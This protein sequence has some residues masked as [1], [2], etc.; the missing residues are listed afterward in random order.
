MSTADRAREDLILALLPVMMMAPTAAEGVAVGVLMALLAPL[1]YALGA[2]AR[3]EAHWRGPTA[4]VIAV[5]LAA[6]ALFATE[7]LW[8][9]VHQ[10][11]VAN[12]MVLAVPC[13]LVAWRAMAPE[14]RARFFEAASITA[15]VVAWPLL[16]GL[17][18]EALGRGTVFADAAAVL[19]DGA[20]RLSLA[21]SSSPRGIIWML[22]P[23]GALL[24]AGA[25]IALERAWHAQ[26]KSPT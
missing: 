22:E 15:R 6:C 23:A 21:A 26:E 14:P 19:G 24:I 8:P 18:R 7:A 17:L 13:A 25:L 10:A 5:M 4:I 11:L 20:A 3:A 16:A 2:I 9:G 12:L 1:A